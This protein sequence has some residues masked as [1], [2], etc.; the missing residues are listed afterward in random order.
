MQLYNRALELTPEFFE[1]IRL[2]RRIATLL[3]DN[4]DPTGAANYY[5]RFIAER[6]T[7]APD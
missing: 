2:H 4:V 6:P 5:R 1:Y 3:M 7:D